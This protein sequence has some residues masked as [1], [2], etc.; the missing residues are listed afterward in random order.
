MSPTQP[1]RPRPAPPGAGGDG[2]AI[3]DATSGTYYRDVKER[4]SPEGT[5][6][7]RDK[8]TEGAVEGS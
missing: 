3:A 7:P 6:G 8:G 4:T 5:E 1:P 2:Q